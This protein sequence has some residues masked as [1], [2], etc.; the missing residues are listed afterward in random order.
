MFR[1][2]AGLKPTGA[3]HPFKT[4]DFVLLYYSIIK[5]Q[6]HASGLTA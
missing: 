1:A 4:K 2:V 6:Q 5:D 3:P